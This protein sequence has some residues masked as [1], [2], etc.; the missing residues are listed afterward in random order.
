MKDK[1]PQSKNTYFILID[2]GG[3]L[4]SHLWFTWFPTL[5]RRTFRDGVINSKPLCGF[6]GATTTIPSLEDGDRS[7]AEKRWE[8]QVRV[9]GIL[10][11]SHHP[12]SR[13][14][15]PGPLSPPS[16][17]DLCDD[18][19]ELLQPRAQ[20]PRQGELFKEPLGR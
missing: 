11:Y 13:L 2:T 9:R 6:T 18:H 12:V 14:L 15:R 17:V 16:R 1:D 20:G 5:T 3:T 10:C 19:R 4:K 7:D 8:G